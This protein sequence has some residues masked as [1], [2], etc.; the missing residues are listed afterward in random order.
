MRS[1]R[2]LRARE[3]GQ[4]VLRG[5]KEHEVVPQGD[6]QLSPLL[7]FAAVQGFCR[8][9]PAGLDSEAPLSRLD[10]PP[11]EPHGQRAFVEGRRLPERARHMA[12]E[13][14]VRRPAAP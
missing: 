3:V 9:E 10:R 4:G 8:D 12:L 7:M 6:A 5:E 14:S 2:K 11:R 1:W 13:A